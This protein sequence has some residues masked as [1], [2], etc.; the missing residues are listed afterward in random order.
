MSDFT[1]FSEHVGA[2]AN[3]HHKATLFSGDHLMVGLNCLE[4]G[5]E[6]AV[7]DH[8]DQDKV[9]QVLEGEG[10]FSVAAEERCAGVGS[11]VWARAGVPHGVRNEGAG[12]LTLLVCIAP[13]P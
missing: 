5:Q 6:Q 1:H 11:V 3:K 8:S 4:P 12:R 7:H 9:Y 2:R 10:V 13:P